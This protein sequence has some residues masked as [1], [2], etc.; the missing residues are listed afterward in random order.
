MPA[1]SDVAGIKPFSRAEAA[2]LL[3]EAEWNLEVGGGSEDLAFARTIMVELRR[4]IPREASLY[5]T[6]QLSPNRKESP[7]GR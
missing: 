2:R 6:R 3:L 7:S 5:S 4:K 1:R